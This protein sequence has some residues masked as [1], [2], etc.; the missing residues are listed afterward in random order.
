MRPYEGVCLSVAN[1]K[2]AKWKI[3][4]IGIDRC[5]LQSLRWTYYGRCL[6]KKNLRSIPCKSIVCLCGDKSQNMPQYWDVC[7]LSSSRFP[8]KKK[9]IRILSARGRINHQS[10]VVELTYLLV[11]G[12][13]MPV[14]T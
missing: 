8:V 13:G 2:M 9:I 12:T 7:N 5:G 4:H 14:T 10:E 11:M 6:A 1:P 3:G